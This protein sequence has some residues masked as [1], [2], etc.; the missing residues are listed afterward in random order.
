MIKSSC[1]EMKEL[2]K[3]PEKLQA[4]GAPSAS[5]LFPFLLPL[6]RNTIESESVSY[7]FFKMYLF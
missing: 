5:L 3:L 6:N 1:E 4:R 7:S 2:G